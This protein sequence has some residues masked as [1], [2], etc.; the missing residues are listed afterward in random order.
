MCVTHNHVGQE[1]LHKVMSESLHT[2][3]I[4]VCMYLCDEL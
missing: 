2:A 1:E 3:H 4:E